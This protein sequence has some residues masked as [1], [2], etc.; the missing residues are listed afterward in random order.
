MK[1]YQNSRRWLLKLASI[2]TTASLV[3]CSTGDTPSDPTPPTLDEA[4]SLFESGEYAKAVE[5]FRTV[6]SGDSTLT[7]GYNGLGW[8]FAFAGMLD[9]ASGHLTTAISKDADSVD[10]LVCLSAVRLAQGD[11]DDAVSLASDA[12][13]LDDSWSFGHYAGVDYLDLRL[14]LAEAYFG[15]GESSFPGAQAQ[16]DILDPSNG[17]DPSDPQTWNGHPTY[18]AAL[19][20][21]I[22]TLEEQIGAEMLL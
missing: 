10:P 16:V 6:L 12:L 13:D 17:L 1:A 19:L 21:V 4:W 9:S 18:T 8:S 20:R 3:G 2:V 15:K 5:T 11:Y 7:D 14:I 22:Q